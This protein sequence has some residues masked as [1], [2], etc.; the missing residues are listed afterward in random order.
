M[1]GHTGEDTTTQDNHSVDHEP[2]TQP[3]SR[4]LRIAM[5]RKDDGILLR[6]EHTVSASTLRTFAPPRMVPSG[7]WARTNSM[8]REFRIMAG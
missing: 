3:S 8:D 5:V 4:N 6:C 1:A 7:T 2:D